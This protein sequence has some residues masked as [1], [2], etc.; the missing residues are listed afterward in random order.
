VCGFKSIAQEVYKQGNE[1]NRYD[2][3]MEKSYI[4]Y[5]KAGRQKK[6]FRSSNHW[7]LNKINHQIGNFFILVHV[8]E[9]ILKHSLINS[10]FKFALTSYIYSGFR[11]SSEPLK[12]LNTSYF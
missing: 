4:S 1:I 9:K 5:L 12:K 2:K 11:L 7:K 8:T 3:Y 10:D 6:C